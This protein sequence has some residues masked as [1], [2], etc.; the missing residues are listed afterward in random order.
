MYSM[1]SDLRAFGLQNLQ[2][3]K[4]SM[5]LSDLR[6][7]G[8]MNLR[9]EEPFVSDLRT[10]GLQNLR[11][12]EQSP[13][14][15]AHDWMTVLDNQTEN[16]AI[17]LD[18]AKAFDKVPHKRLLSKLTSY[19]ITGNTHNLITSFLSNP[20]RTPQML[21]L[22]SHRAQFWDIYYSCS[23]STTS[24]KTFNQLSASFQ[25][26][27]LYIKNKHRSS[28]SSNRHNNSNREMANAV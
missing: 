12:R 6:N 22:V 4:L 28:N 19:G 20:C 23:T 2:H 11:T 14:E 3:R 7:F 17:L 25:M 10:F 18:V 5:S 1:H 27:A 16:D 9:N 24:T 8:L 26:I 15:T 21:H 13:I